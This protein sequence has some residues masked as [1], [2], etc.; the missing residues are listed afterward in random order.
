MS[1]RKFWPWLLPLL[2]VEHAWSAEAPRP[3]SKPNVLFLFADDQRADT[4]AALGNPYIITP[5]LDRLVHSGV[6]F[7][8]AYM[9]GGLQGATCVPSRAMV[10]SGR[11]L[12]SIDEKLLR[13]ETW[14]RAFAKAGYTTFM[15]G[16]WH[17]GPESI[18]MSFQIARSIFAGGMTDPLNAPL[19][20]M[21]DGKLTEPK[22]A[23]KHACAIF[24]DEAIRFLSEP[25]DEPF[26]C[27]VAFDAPH[28]PHIVPDDFPIR[29]DADKI[30]LPANFLPQHPFDN[31]DMVQRDE[32]LLPWP[33]P[34]DQIRQMN[35]EYARYISYLD[36]Q[37]GRILDA[38][39]GSPYAKNTIVVFSADSGVARGSHGLIGKQNMYEESVRVPLVI[40]GPGIAAN[41][42]TSAMCY[43]FDLMPTLG[44]LCD[45]TSPS[46][47][48]GVEFT[49]VLKDPTKP[50]RP[51]LMFAFKTVQRACRDERWKLIRYP[52]INKSQLFDLEHDPW[53]MV[54]LADNLEYAPRLEIMTALLEKEKK[55]FG[56]NAPL[57]VANPQPAGWSPPSKTPKTGK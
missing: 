12:F 13:D 8:R 38:L 25:K 54:D 29:Y 37:I 33:R 44:R 52:H 20:N 16:K 34:K 23:P 31:G 6:S 24:A 39:E 49:A 43:H 4:I 46:T 9:Q 55:R 5:N 14:P 11:P 51:Q 45:V 17:N 47:S 1:F 35:A 10:L 7:K 18:P 3:D 41:Q 36:A 26:F 50:A 42:T 40:A 30:P 57:K 53:E 28:D 48:E 22:I 27:Y 21:I 19:S 32:E 15:T 2:L 56:D